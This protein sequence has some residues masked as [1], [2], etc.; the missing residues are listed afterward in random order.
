[1]RK[2]IGMLTLMGLLAVNTLY[3][4]VFAQELKS[5]DKDLHYKSIM[6]CVDTDPNPW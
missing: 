4:T 5:T 3:G 2:R 6:V 1:M